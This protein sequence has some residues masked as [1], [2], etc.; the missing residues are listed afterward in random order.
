MI[1]SPLRFLL[2]VRYVPALASTACFILDS[3]LVRSL[4]SAFPP[5]PLGTDVAIC[6]HGK[7]SPNQYPFGRLFSCQGTQRISYP[8]TM[9]STLFLDLNEINFSFYPVFHTFLKIY[10]HFFKI[11]YKIFYFLQIFFCFLQRFQNSPHPVFH[12]FFGFEPNFL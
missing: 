3:S 5:F 1:L 12:T 2:S 4:T 10:N 6:C 7:E 11:F 9:Y 8:S